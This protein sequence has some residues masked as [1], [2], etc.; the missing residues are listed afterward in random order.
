M[1]HREWGGAHVSTSGE[2]SVINQKPPLVER[3]EDSTRGMRCNFLL[4]GLGSWSG[5]KAGINENN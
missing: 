5:F 1:I 3:L 4:R 2:T